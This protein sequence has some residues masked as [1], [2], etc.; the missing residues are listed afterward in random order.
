MQKLPG[1]AGRQA[2]SAGLQY[3][4]AGMQQLV[5]SVRATGATNVL[6]LGGIQNASNLDRWTTFAP[7]DP[8]HQLAAS[9]HDYSFGICADVTCWNSSLSSIGKVP[10]ITGE[11]GE[12]D[13]SAAYIEGYMDWADKHG[14][15]Y[16]AWTWDTWGCGNAAVLVE[17]YTGTPCPSYGTGYQQHLAQVSSPSNT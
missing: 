4:A 11:I 14:V 10:L 9:L 7:A 17:N 5:A 1:S 6:M 13:G 2:T 12:N 8:D 3:Q 15:S 16:L